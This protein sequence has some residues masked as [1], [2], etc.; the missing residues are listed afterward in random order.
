MLFGNLVE[1]L[2][3]RLEEEPDTPEEPHEA[4]GILRQ[5]L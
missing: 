4:K 3:E 2:A 1:R 5:I